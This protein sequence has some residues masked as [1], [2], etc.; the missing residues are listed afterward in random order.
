ML[1]DEPPVN[2]A[3]MQG[4]KALEKKERGF[5]ENV[6]RKY[7]VPFI[8]DCGEADPKILDSYRK[9][10]AQDKY[11]KWVRQVSE[12]K[13]DIDGIAYSF[14]KIRSSFRSKA[15]FRGGPRLSFAVEVEVAVS[16]DRKLIPLE[17]YTHG[18][19]GSGEATD[20]SILKEKLKTVLSRI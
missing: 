15:D 20:I 5:I 10:A 14:I 16:S 8:L 19:R 1:Y 18:M 11:K 2:P 9:V 6:Y 13:E 7:L 12:Q 4:L 17:V 3:F